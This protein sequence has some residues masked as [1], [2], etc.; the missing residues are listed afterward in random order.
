MP[1]RC[2]YCSSTLNEQKSTRGDGQPFQE[3]SNQVSN[4]TSPL[5]PSYMLIFGE[6][7]LQSM[8]KAFRVPMLLTNFHVGW[9][10]P[11]GQLVSAAMDC[12]KLG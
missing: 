9:R 2:Q 5:T 10:A 12:C 4:V 11:R 8:S 1:F 3:H 6:I 7:I